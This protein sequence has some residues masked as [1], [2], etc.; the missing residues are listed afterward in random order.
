MQFCAEELGTCEECFPLDITTREERLKLCSEMAK[1]TNTR[2]MR[3]YS[4]S[5]A[6]YH[7]F[8]HGEISNYTEQAPAKTTKEL[9]DGLIAEYKSSRHKQLRKI[10]MD[11]KNKTERLSYL[12]DQ[13][14]NLKINGQKQDDKMVT[15][16]I[17]GTTSLVLATTIAIVCIILRVMWWLKQRKRKYKCKK[18]EPDFEESKQLFQKKNI[19]EN[20]RFKRL[21]SDPDNIKCIQD[22]INK[23]LATVKDLPLHLKAFKDNKY[24]SND[25]K[26]GCNIEDERVVFRGN[27]ERKKMKKNMSRKN[28]K[29]LKKGEDLAIHWADKC[30]LTSA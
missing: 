5:P 28:K 11:I 12:E 3:H 13:V 8:S 2:S 6:C 15:L 4:C 19:L 27:R 7:S 16:L 10:R 1:S 26:S 30:F 24:Q 22:Q 25:N 20:E 9:I 21:L 14:Q 29:N 18:I 17:I 23:Y